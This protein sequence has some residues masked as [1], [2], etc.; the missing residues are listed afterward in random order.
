MCVMIE[1][2]GAGV[3]LT[4]ALGAKLRVLFV[5]PSDG[6]VDGALTVVRFQMA[7]ALCAT[8]I[9]NFPKAYP[10]VVLTMAGPAARADRLGGVVGGR[11]V[12]GQAC[13]VGHCRAVPRGSQ[14]AHAAI[15]GEH[16]VSRGERTF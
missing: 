16:C 5:E 13:L 4:R 14:V 12:A 11:I 1:I 3:R 2:N 8:R 9:R 7:V 10:S 15:T 6:G